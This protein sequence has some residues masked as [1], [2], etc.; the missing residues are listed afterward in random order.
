[1]AAKKLTDVHHCLI[2]AYNQ[3]T[4]TTN[5]KIEVSVQF[6][7]PTGFVTQKIT[8]LWIQFSSTAGPDGKQVISV[9]EESLSGC[10]RRNS[11]GTPLWLFF[12]II[13]FLMSSCL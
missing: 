7:I 2:P 5:L 8:D 4:C 9:R 10:Y 1:H 11:H 12:S 6:L 3:S 13:F